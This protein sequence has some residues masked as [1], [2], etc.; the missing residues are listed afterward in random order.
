M[1][2]KSIDNRSTKMWI[3]MDEKPLTFV[4]FGSAVKGPKI[5]A[6]IPITTNSDR[7]RLRK[8]QHDF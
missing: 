7:L 3:K 4:C 2:E 1:F 5:H 8:K 6:G